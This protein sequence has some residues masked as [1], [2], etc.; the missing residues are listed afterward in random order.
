MNV[1]ISMPLAIAKKDVLPR[2][3]GRV[4]IGVECNVSRQEK[5]SHVAHI[6]RRGIH[7]IDLFGGLF[8]MCV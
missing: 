1:K 8:F 3:H 5:P 4:N 2:F 7:Q 6:Q